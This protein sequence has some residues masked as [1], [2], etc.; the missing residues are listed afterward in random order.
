LCTALVLVCLLAFP[1][2]AAAQSSWEIVRADYGTGNNWVDVTDRVRSLVQGDSL[3]FRVDG[4]LLGAVSRRG[5]NRVLRLQLKDSAGRSRQ[6]TYRDSQQVNLRVRT[7]YRSSLHISRAVYG[8][9]NRSVD[10][11]SRVNSQIQGDQLNLLVNNASMGGDPAPGQAKTL[12]LEY[13]LNGRTK[14]VVINEGDTLRLTYGATS[15]SNLQITRAIYGSGYRTSDV[16]SRLNSQIQGDQLNLLVNN[17]S[18][19][20]D[21]AP[22]QAKTLTVQYALNGQTSE[23]VVN[24]GDTLRLPYGATS[25]S[26]LQIT[27]AIYGSGYRTSDVTARLNSQIQDDQLNLQVN[28]ES[29]GGDP[30]P[31]QAKTLTLEYALNGRTNQVVINEG[32]TLRLPY[33]ATSQSNLQITRARYGAGNRTSDVTSRLN[34]QI[35]GDQ[36]NLQVNSASMG[37]DPA[38]GQAKTLT[39]QYALNGQTNQVVINEGDTLRLPYDSTSDLSQR[40]RCESVQSDGYGRKYCAANTRNGVRLVRQIGESACTQGSSW[41]YDNS[42]VWVDNGCRAEFEMRANGRSSGALTT[43]IPNGTEISVRTNE[44]IDSRNATVGQQFSGVIAADILD[45]SGAVMIPRGSDAELVIRS[46]NSGGT[47]SG[48]DLVLDINSIT[49][50]GTRYLVSTDDLQRQ[51]GQGVGANRRTAVMVGGGAVLGTLIGA[52]AGGGQGAAIGAAVGAGAGLG[53]E[54]L[55]KGRQVRVPA[56]TLLRFRLD[57]DLRLQEMR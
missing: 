5:L 20:G 16:T 18:M 9:G 33:D 2:L 4:N 31:G 3:N 26:N 35:Q 22:R 23:V 17:D 21:P 10:V 11:T 38:P 55:T 14:Q 50:S 27:R 57:Q 6:I 32:D 28:R 12:T 29:M 52:I 24:E 41:G 39:V 1:L 48:S 46:A 37:G 30:A 19:G 7:V 15:Q 53:A 34:S 43:T 40:I 51:G 13:A 49:V 44:T 54:V 56:E 42:G 25:Q 45:S 8:S 47:T 36:L